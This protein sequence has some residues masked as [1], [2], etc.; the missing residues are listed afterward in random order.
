MRGADGI[1]AHLRE[2]R[3]HIRD[4]DIAA[5]DYAPLNFGS[6]DQ[7]NDCHCTE[8][9]PNA[10]CIVPERRVTT[11]A[12]LLVGNGD[13]LTDLLSPLREAGIRLSL[14]IEANEADIDSK[15]D[16]C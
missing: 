14:F 8:T 15:A 12:V 11:E 16:W 2:D 10:A 1:T 9:K 4:D 7:R 3:R 6:G 13:R 5:G